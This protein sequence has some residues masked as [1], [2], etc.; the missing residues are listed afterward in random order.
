MRCIGS[1]GIGVAAGSVPLEAARRLA[2]EKAPK[3]HLAHHNLAE[4]LV[5]G[6]RP[7]NTAAL[8]RMDAFSAG[9]RE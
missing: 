2:V 5:W 7:G 8:K 9:R 6:G 3:S 1:P 4:A